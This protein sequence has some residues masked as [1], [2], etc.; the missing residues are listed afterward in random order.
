MS[1]PSKSANKSNGKWMYIDRV[2]YCAEKRHHSPNLYEKGFDSCTTPSQQHHNNP[3]HKS[4]PQCM[5]LTLMWRVIVQLLY[6]CCKSNI[7]L[8]KIQNT[9]LMLTTSQRSKY[10]H[11]SL[12]CLVFTRDQDCLKLILG[13]LFSCLWLVTTHSIIVMLYIRVVHANGY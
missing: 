11:N 2:I 7:F 4:R 9:R 13:Q 1:P 5:S 6:W 3:S 8:M 12:T 10:L